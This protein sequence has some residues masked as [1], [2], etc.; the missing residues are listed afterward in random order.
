MLGLR[1][2]FLTLIR[3]A[4]FV[5]CAISCSQTPKAQGSGV[6]AGGGLA[7]PGTSRV[8]QR[9]HPALHTLKLEGHGAPLNASSL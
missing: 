4:R 7:Q 9:I 2:A 6:H 8:N 3:G 5:E 1:C